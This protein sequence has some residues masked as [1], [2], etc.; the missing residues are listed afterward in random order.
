MINKASEEAERNILKTNQDFH[1][2]MG[3]ERKTLKKE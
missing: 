3:Q 2:L 1:S